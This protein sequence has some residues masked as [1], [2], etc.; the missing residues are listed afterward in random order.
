MDYDP[1]YETD[2]R[3]ALREWLAF[4]REACIRKLSGVTEVRARWVPTPT[5]NSLIGIVNHLI[6]VEHWWFH[7]CFDGK[8]GLLPRYGDPTDEDYDFKPPPGATVD[9]T[10]EAYRAEIARSNGIEK[11]AESLDLLA[12][13]DRVCPNLRWIMVHMIE[14]TARHAGHMDI[15]REL[16]DGSTG[17]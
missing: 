9:G 12:A 16:V 5:A 2:E 15:T 10:I 17:L 13:H 3:T 7:T 8:E 1:G 4:E 6:Y 11:N 14:E